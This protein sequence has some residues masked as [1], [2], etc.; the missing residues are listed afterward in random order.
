MT[1]WAL[2]WPDTDKKI[3][4]YPPLHLDAGTCT[5]ALACFVARG[6][7]AFENGSCVGAQGR[8]L[9]SSCSRTHA[10]RPGGRIWDAAV[11]LSEF[12]ACRFGYEEGGGGEG[13]QATQ[14]PPALAGLQ[15]VDV[16]AGTGMAGVVCAKLGARVCITDKQFVLPLIWANATLNSAEAVERG[17]V[18]GEAL[19]W[20]QKLPKRLKRLRTDLIVASDVVGCGDE[21]L[22][23]GLIKT[24]LDLSAPHTLTIMTYKPR[25]PFEHLFFAAARRHFTVRRVARAL[26]PPGGGLEMFSSVVQ[27]LV[28]IPNASPLP[29]QPPA[30]VRAPADA[31]L[32]GSGRSSPVSARA[33]GGGPAERL[34]PVALPVALPVASK[35]QRHQAYHQEG[36][37][38]G[39]GDGRERGVSGEGGGGGEGGPAVGSLTHA[40][41]LDTLRSEG[42]EFDWE[43]SQF[44][45]AHIDH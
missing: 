26:L 10:H 40:R 14:P 3:N 5:L 2:L 42:Q 27:V 8:I 36:G 25:A 39:G 45:F 22:Y 37:G 18:W 20:G 24:L 28:L 7:P 34:A 21:A 9:T 13:Q 1:V 29:V 38:G 33:G 44:S 19:L 11:V 17:E 15:V 31:Y 32:E 23:P 35:R 6:V 12:L 41:T 43:A 30:P 16:G 4:E